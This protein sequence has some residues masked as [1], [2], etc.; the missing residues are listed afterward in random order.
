M[1]ADDYGLHSEL[2]GPLPV[3]NHFVARMG[4]MASLERFVPGDDAR[5]RLAPALVL[6]VVVRNLRGLD[7]PHLA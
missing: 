2:L 7:I 6:G 5:L 3:I 1:S 4:L